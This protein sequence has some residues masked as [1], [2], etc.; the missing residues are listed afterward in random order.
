[1]LFDKHIRR[2]LEFGREGTSPSDPFL[3]SSATP[4]VAPWEESLRDYPRGLA[5][6]KSLALSNEDRLDFTSL[7]HARILPKYV[8][9]P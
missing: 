3:S 6:S 1:M 5:A 2:S 9:I 7:P 4:R 8:S